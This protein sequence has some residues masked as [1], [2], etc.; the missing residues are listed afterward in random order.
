M[1]ETLLAH[2]DRFDLV[3]AVRV[4]EAEAAAQGCGRRDPVRFI[5]EV[6]LR[7][8][9]AAISD[10]R[11]MEDGG[12]RL[13]VALMGLMGPQGVLPFSYT[14]HAIQSRHLHDEALSD[15]LDIFQH[16]AISLFCDAARKYRIALSQKPAQEPDDTFTTV[17]ASLAS[18]GF[19]SM[20]GRMEVDHGALLGSAGLLSAEARPMAGLQSLLSQALGE[21][22]IIHPFVGTWVRLPAEECTRLGG[23]VNP[24]GQH[25]RL[26][27]GAMLGDRAFVAQQNFRIEIGPVDHARLHALLPGTAAAARVR[28]LVE[29]YCGLEFSF[30][31]NVKVA[32]AEVPAARLA[33]GPQDDGA[34]RLGQTSWLLDG[35]SPVPRDDALF[36]PGT[37]G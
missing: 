14:T 34:G 17:L 35:P 23:A 9:E 33:R 18:L 8:P 20:Q 31:L 7:Y 22:V 36:R 32:A 12:V 21:P 2:P 13:T 11:R 5:G 19:S 3:Q 28:D 26:G 27:G 16:R 24:Q 37:L 29:L 15:F 4:I 1:I 10:A 6:S 30:D 25:A